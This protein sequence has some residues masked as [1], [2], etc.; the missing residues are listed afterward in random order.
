MG[1]RWQQTSLLPLLVVPKERRMRLMP[2]V[3]SGIVENGLALPRDIQ[4]GVQA[5]CICYEIYS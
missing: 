3:K 1:L 4:S 2:M 5:R